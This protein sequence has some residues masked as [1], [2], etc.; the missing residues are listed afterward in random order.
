MQTL[1]LLLVQ[2]LRRNSCKLG[3]CNLYVRL[4]VED[5][6]NFQKIQLWSPKIPD[7]RF[8][9]PKDLLRNASTKNVYASFELCSDI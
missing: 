9:N 4:G 6:R 1:E 3:V 2:W 8:R 5:C 7:K